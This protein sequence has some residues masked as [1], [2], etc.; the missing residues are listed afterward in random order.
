MQ[1]KNHKNP[2]TI[3]CL[4]IFFFLVTS[5][6]T[7]YNIGQKSQNPVQVTNTN[8]NIVGSNINVKEVEKI[9]INTCSKEA[10][11][12]LPGIGE[13]LASRIIKNRPYI[14]IYELLKVDG[15]GEKTLEQIKES[16]VV[17]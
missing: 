7:F 15:L 2:L 14:D 8:T 9:N 6:L 11:E 1:H 4:L 12:S 5:A 17:K 13:T 16:V 3:V 10:L